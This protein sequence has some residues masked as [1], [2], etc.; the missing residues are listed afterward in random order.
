LRPIERAAFF[1]SYSDKTFK[2]LVQGASAAFGNAA[3]RLEAFVVKGG[4]YAY[5]SFHD[6]DELFRQQAVELD[7]QR[8]QVLLARMQQLVHERTIY[9]S[10]W[11]LGA[12]FGVGSRVAESTLGLIAGYPRTSPYEDLTRKGT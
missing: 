2:G 4:A 9:A 12:M 5:G 1:K 11:Q 3:T 6:I 10:I 7:H 8:R